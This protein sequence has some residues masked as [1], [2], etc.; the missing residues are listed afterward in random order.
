MLNV[1]LLLGLVPGLLA[2]APFQFA[3][4]EHHEDVIAEYGKEI[5]LDCTTFDTNHS[6]VEWYRNDSNRAVVQ[7][8]EDRHMLISANYTGRVDLKKKHLH[9]KHVKFEDQAVYVCRTAVQKGEE[10]SIQHGTFWKLIVKH[11]EL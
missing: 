8:L 7:R 10:I 4:E 2:K 5:T 11:E 6:Y 9:I 1:L 3:P